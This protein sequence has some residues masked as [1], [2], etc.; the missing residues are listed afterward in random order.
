[1]MRIAY[2]IRHR[3]AHLATS[4]SDLGASEILAATPMLGYAQWKVHRVVGN[5]KAILAHPSHSRERRLGVMWDEEPSPNISPGSGI[6]ILNVEGID[7]SGE[8]VN[9]LSSHASPKSSSQGVVFGVYFCLA[10]TWLG[11]KGGP[12]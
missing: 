3:R 1:M 5:S 6:Y 9:C 7:A 8:L 10:S 2:R 12:R 11:I 4:L